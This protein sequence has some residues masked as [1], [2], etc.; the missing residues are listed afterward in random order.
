MILT[1]RLNEDGLELY[2]KYEHLDIETILRLLNNLHNLHNII[3]STTSPIYYNQRGKQAFRNILDLT[4]IT[5]GQSVRIKIS[6]KWKIE[7]PFGLGK[8][9][10]AFP[11]KLGVPLIIAVFILVA[12]R[13]SFEIYNGYLDSQLKEL[14]IEVEKNELYQQMEERKRIEPEFRKATREA[15]KTINFII[16]NAEINYFE[17]NGIRLKDNR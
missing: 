4:E 7:L 3:V 15:T 10:G 9:E 2:F 12:A 14:E 1:D 5:T 13:Q 6:E 17:L 16:D 8:V 11:K